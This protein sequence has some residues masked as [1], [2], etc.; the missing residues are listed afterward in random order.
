MAPSS[1]NDNND[2]ATKALERLEWAPRR[3]RKTRKFF[4]HH[5]QL[6]D[7]SFSILPSCAN[8]SWP[9]DD[10]DEDDENNKTMKK[11]VFDMTDLYNASRPIEYCMEFPHISWIHDEDSSSGHPHH[12]SA[13]FQRRCASY[14]DALVAPL[15]SSTLVHN[16]QSASSLGK[17]SRNQRRCMSMGGASSAPSRQQQ[18]LIRSIAWDDGLAHIES[19]TASVNSTNTIPSIPCEPQSIQDTTEILRIRIEEGG[20]SSSGSS[21]SSSCSSTEHR[22]QHPRQQRRLTIPNDDAA[23]L[24]FAHTT[25]HTITAG[26]GG[27]AV[28]LV[29][30]TTT[31]SSFHQD[32]VQETL[33]ILQSSDLAIE[34][35][36]A[37]SSSY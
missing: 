27:G 19:T 2:R 23:T 8:E 22:S 25:A 18:R 30:N 4:R 3:E 37:S 20:T 11:N 5:H 32:R 6:E 15:H 34:K 17:R 29:H 33:R 10:S 1:C 12:S 31:S 21:R 16:S 24:Y 7:S 35:H 14:S 26:E 28:P 9:K 13:L 36:F